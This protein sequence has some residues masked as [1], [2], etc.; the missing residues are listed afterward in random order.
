MG[1]CTSSQPVS[2][3][4]IARRTQAKNEKITSSSDGTNMLMTGVVL[5]I[6]IDASNHD[7]G[8]STF[9]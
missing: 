7:C 6:A 9:D 5:A 8:S 2:N 4:Y 3:D 1:S